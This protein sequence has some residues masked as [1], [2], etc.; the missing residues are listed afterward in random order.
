MEQSVSTNIKAFNKA[1]ETCDCKTEALNAS[2]EKE[3]LASKSLRDIKLSF[4]GVIK[5][6]TSNYMKQLADCDDDKADDE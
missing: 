3:K 5:E 2:L 1:L 4:I 6:L